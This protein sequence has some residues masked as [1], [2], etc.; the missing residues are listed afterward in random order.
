MFFIFILIIA[1]SLLSCNSNAIK[2]KTEENIKS[3]FKQYEVIFKEIKEHL[4]KENGQ[5]KNN[6]LYGR[7]LF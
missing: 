1:A 2:K 4:T 3:E 5:L 7:I 6:Q